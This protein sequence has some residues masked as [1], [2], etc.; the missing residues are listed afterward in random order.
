MVRR[1]VMRRRDRSWW[2]RLLTPAPLELAERLV[3]H[4]AAEIRLARGLDED[5]QSLAQYPAPR[6]QV[7]E[8]VQRA[9]GRAERVRGALEDLGQTVKEPATENGQRPSKTWERLRAG[10]SELSSMSEA[11][12]AD[13]YAVQRE[14]P[15]IASLLD[16]LYR[17]TAR[18]HRDL[19]WMLAQLPWAAGNSGALKTNTV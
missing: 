16:E 1:P 15:G 5:A 7:L 12:L 2:Q 8:A 18:D 6:A 14:H 17:E 13:A 11:C 4:Y 3:R 10:I 9:R 19:I